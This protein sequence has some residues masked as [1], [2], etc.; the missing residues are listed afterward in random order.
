MET[1]TASPHEPVAQRRVLRYLNGDPGH[2]EVLLDLIKV[3]P[4]MVDLPAAKGIGGDHSS[5]ASMIALTTTPHRSSW[6]PRRAPSAAM[7]LS[8]GWLFDT[9]KNPEYPVPTTNRT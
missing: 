4:G 9:P 7:S 8:Y 2:D 6:R 1:G 3:R 5:S